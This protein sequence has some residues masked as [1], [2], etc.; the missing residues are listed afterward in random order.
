MA[1]KVTMK[2]KIS[3]YPSL[4]ILQFLS[5]ET[6][7]LTRFY[8]VCI[9]QEKKIHVYIYNACIFMYIYPYAYVQNGILF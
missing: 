6:T 7:I 5:I 4:P 3:F 2:I 1:K 9:L 8:V